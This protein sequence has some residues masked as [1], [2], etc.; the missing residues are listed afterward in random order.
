MLRLKI[1]IPE[2]FEGDKPWALVAAGKAVVLVQDAED[3]AAG[4]AAD[5]PKGAA[6]MTSMSGR[7]TVAA[8]PTGMQL[9]NIAPPPLN[10]GTLSLPE[11]CALSQAQTGLPSSNG[12]AARTTRKACL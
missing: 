7:A 4:A 5:T 10:S 12:A 9:M 3:E 6:T 1:E 11:K 8:V 2:Q